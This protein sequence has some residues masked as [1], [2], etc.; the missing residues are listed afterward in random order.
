MMN[1]ALTNVVG[2]K[3]KRFHLEM[4]ALKEAPASELKE[5]MS[6]LLPDEN[7][8]NKPNAT[9]R[10][11]RLLEAKYNE[12][13]MYHEGRLVPFRFN[14]YSRLTM[15]LRAVWDGVHGETSSS[16]SKPTEPAPKKAKKMP[17]GWGANFDGAHEKGDAV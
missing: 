4:V 16:K 8:T 17:L 2:R 12:L 5:M 13:P 6:Q 11:A 9:V 15:P 1:L 10:I 3:Y 14:A 7:Y